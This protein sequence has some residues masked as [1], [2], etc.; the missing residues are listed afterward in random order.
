MATFSS[1][2]FDYS[3]WWRA[4]QFNFLI[5]IC[6]VKGMMLMGD[7]PRQ[8]WVQFPALLRFS[9]YWHCSDSIWL[10]GHCALSIGKK[11]SCVSY[12]FSFSESLILG[13]FFKLCFETSDSPSNF[14]NLQKSCLLLG[15][16]ARS[17]CQSF[18]NEFTSTCS[19]IQFVSRL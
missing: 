3:T 1:D 17:L 2:F 12:H 5:I 19:Q 11:Y 9:P 15:P 16:K 4:S 13:Y 7:G 18:S 10:M 14:S 6:E 8:T